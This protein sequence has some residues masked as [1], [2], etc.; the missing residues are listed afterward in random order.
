MI[1]HD[2]VQN[3]NEWHKVRAAIPTA[4][5]IDKIITPATMLDALNGAEKETP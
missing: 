4:S 5:E 1:F 2:V 3:T